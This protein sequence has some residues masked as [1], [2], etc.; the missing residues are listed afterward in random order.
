V[1]V[2]QRLVAVGVAVTLGGGIG[3]LGVR[4]LDDSRPVTVDEAV[5][6]FRTSSPSAAPGGS[7]GPSPTASAAPTASAGATAAPGATAGPAASSGPSA[8][9]PSA[10]P[11]PPAAGPR[12][13]SGVYAYATTGYETADAGIPRARHDYPAETGV[14]I[15]DVPC[16][17]SVRWDA[18]EDR[19]DDVTICTGRDHTKVTAY[20]S[21][22]R[23]FGQS[24]TRSYTCGGDSYLRPPPGVRRWTF[25][26]TTGDAH[27][28]TVGTVVGTETVGGA[29]ALHVHYDTTLTGT[30]Q[31]T[32]PQDFWIALDGPYVLR[33]ASEVDAR[34]TT[35]YGTITYHEQY[36]L[37]LKSRT[38]RR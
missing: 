9:A 5:Q 31:G 20:V 34:V 26:C 7:A 2:V 15:R 13:P 22:H 33:Q 8:A 36:D 38:P 11:R 1:S 35:P 17:S 29:R 21:F 19:W 18:N 12:T 6:R 4:H 3:M 24:E 14:T 16:G 27:A 37:V 30:N 25:D 32:N 23:F 10:T 28:R